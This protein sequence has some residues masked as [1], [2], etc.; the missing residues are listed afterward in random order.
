MTS[1]IH[2]MKDVIISI[3]VLCRIDPTV[4]GKRT[5]SG[6][7]NMHENCELILRRIPHL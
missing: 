4:Y 5:L 3:L 1:L 6:L 7:V 2:S